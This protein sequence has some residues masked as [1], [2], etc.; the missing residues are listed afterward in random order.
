MIYCHFDQICKISVDKTPEN[1]ELV[2]DLRAYTYLLVK[3]DPE[4]IL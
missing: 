2:V 3:N 4:T 1:A